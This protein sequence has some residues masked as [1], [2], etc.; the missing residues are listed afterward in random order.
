MSSEVRR[1]R[2]RSDSHYGLR[3]QDREN[4]RRYE[5][6]TSP[7]PGHRDLSIRYPGMTKRS[8]D[9]LISLLDEVVNEGSAD[10]IEEEDGLRY[11]PVEVSQ[12]QFETAHSVPRSPPGASFQLI[13]PSSPSEIQSDGVEKGPSDG[14]R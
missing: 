7:N 4:R 9:E 6:E 10:Q 2:G 8:F 12:Q 5:G 11:C 14:D 13:L 1:K 3:Q